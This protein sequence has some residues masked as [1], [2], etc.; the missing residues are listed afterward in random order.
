MSR[1]GRLGN[2][3][4]KKESTWG[5]YIAGDL[6]LRASTE[7]LA[8]KI[9]N[10]EDPSLVGQIFPTDQIKVAE[11]VEGGIEGVCQPD[12]IGVLL[13]G[14]LGGESSAVGNGTLGHIVVSYNGANAYERITKATTNLTVEK[15]TLGSSWIGD[16]T[17]G[18]AGV[19]D[20]SS[21]LYD[22]LGLLTTYISSIS[23]FDAVL[24][25]SSTAGSTNIANFSATNLK[26]ASV[27]VGAKILDCE[28]SVSTTAK[29]HSLFSALATQELPSYSFTI[30]RV[31]GTNQSLGYIGCKIKS[32]SIQ[33]SAK[34]LSKISIS[35]DGKQEL[36][37]Q[38]DISLTLPTAQAFSSNNWKIV[39][40]DSTGNLT[41]F[42]EVKDLSININSNVDDNRVVGSLYKKEQIRQKGTIDISMTANNTSTQ[43]ALRTSYLNSTGVSVYLYVKSATLIDSTNSVPYSLLIRIPEIKFTDF[44]SPLNTPDRLTITAAG[45]VIKPKNTTYTQHI[46]C[47]VVD[48]DIT[49]Y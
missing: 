10:V 29:K 24:L 38:T 16:S 36:T 26:S 7:S 41:E 6:Y 12:T 44:A 35:L 13:H 40:E 2:I 17:F 25:G 39:F 21:S 30:N 20:L 1:T 15:S 8:N 23:G 31:L 43:Y 4:F 9:D 3:S 47:Y 42:D 27:K 48:N 18:T 22:N 34:D 33:Q 49:T 28:S 19:L 5:S 37:A 14:V 11:G 32:L 45:S 46:Y